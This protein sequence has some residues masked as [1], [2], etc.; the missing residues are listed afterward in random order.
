MHELGVTEN[1]VNIALSKAEEAQAS[2]IL[3]I[4]IVIGE[5]SGFVPDCIDFYFNSLSKDTI[6]MEAKLDFDIIPARFRCRDCSTISSP[7][8]MLWICPSCQ[9]HSMEVTGGQEFYIKDLEVE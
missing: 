1:I 4:T 5:L 8:G 3:K 7:E 2:K 9:S 6:A